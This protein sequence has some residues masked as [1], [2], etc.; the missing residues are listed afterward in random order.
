MIVMKPS[1]RKRIA[2]ALHVA[3]P[4]AVIALGILV[5]LVI[6]VLLR[7][8]LRSTTSIP[9]APSISSPTFNVPAAELREPPLPYSADT[10]PK[11]C[12]STHSSR[13]CCPLSRAGASYAIG[14]SC[15]TNRSAGLNHRPQCSTLR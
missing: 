14:A 12:T 2:N 5:L 4:P 10:S 15:S 9:S 6:I 13:Y 11:R 8:L 1:A 3:A 7:F